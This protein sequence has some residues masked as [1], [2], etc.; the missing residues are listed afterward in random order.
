MR[1]WHMANGTHAF[2]YVIYITFHVNHPSDAINTFEI[3]CKRVSTRRMLG[4]RMVNVVEWPRVVGLG[5]LK[6]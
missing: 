4:I 1:Y 3:Y 2:I 6:I 5:L